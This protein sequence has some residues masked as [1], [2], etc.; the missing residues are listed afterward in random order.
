[1]S[2]KLRFPVPMLRSKRI[3]QIPETEAVTEKMKKI[4]EGRKRTLIGTTEQDRS[5]SWRFGLAA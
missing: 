4:S 1:M 3:P 5:L 2:R